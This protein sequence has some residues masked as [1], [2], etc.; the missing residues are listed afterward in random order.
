M[1][2]LRS[3]LLRAYFCQG[4]PFLM[5]NLALKFF[6]SSHWDHEIAGTIIVKYFVIC[7]MYQIRCY[8]TVMPIARN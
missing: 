2:V 5:E 7:F 1:N 4:F 6:T 8:I 3:F